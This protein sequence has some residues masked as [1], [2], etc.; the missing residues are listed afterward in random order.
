[1]PS[2]H[3]AEKACPG[4]HA[5]LKEAIDNFPG[6][7]TV[8]PDRRRGQV[9]TGVDGGTGSSP[10]SLPDDESEDS[11]ESGWGKKWP[12]PRT[13]LAQM[14][15]D[16]GKLQDRLQV[17]RTAQEERISELT[18]ENQQLKDH[19]R[20]VELVQRCPQQQP[21]AGGG[22]AAEVPLPT[23]PPPPPPPPPS[24]KRKRNED[25]EDGDESDARPKAPPPLALREFLEVEARG[26]V[27]CRQAPAP[28]PPPGLPAPPGRGRSCPRKEARENYLTL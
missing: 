4:L 11:S 26:I 15:L 10:D 25:G 16:L 8:D 12:G 1:M 17:E 6:D 3:G 19:L 5:P 20:A 22:A 9:Q 23:R 27:N 2:W 21:G 18:E 7:V 13:Q 28:P 14:K 24:R